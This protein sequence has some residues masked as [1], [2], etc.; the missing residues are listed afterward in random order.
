MKR[1][2]LIVILFFNAL[3][4]AV[5]QYAASPDSVIYKAL[6]CFQPNKKLPVF[7]FDKGENTKTVTDTFWIWNTTRNDIPIYLNPYYHA[8]CSKSE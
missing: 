1:L 3:C 7:Y 6:E 4:N 2:V 5:A 8:Q